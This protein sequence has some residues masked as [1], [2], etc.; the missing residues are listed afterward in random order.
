MEAIKNFFTSEGFKE[1]WVNALKWFEG[2]LSLLF[3]NIK[4]EPIKNLFTN[5]WFWIILICLLIISLVFR[6]R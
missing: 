6:R 3:G 4:Y 2:V 5:T 1:F